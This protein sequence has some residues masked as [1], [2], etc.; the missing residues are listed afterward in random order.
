MDAINNI[1]KLEN[2]YRLKEERRLIVNELWR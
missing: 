2:E 1:N